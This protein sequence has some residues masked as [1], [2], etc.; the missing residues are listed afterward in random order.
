MYIMGHHR[1]GKMGEERREKRRTELL[2]CSFRHAPRD[3]SDH[4]STITSLP[5]AEALEFDGTCPGACY[6]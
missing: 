2:T 6:E 1:A 3:H 4:T 5:S